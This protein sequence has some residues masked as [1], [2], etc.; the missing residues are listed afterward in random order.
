MSNPFISLNNEL[1][2]GFSL[3]TKALFLLTNS[4][5]LL[6]KNILPPTI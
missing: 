3:P 2:I 4:F 5:L 1:L 6:E